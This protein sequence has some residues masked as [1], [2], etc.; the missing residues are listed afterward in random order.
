[1]VENKNIYKGLECSCNH[2]EKIPINRRDLGLYGDVATYGIAITEAYTAYS[3]DK[4]LKKKANKIQKL[5]GGL[6]DNGAKKI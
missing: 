2:F 1:M 5:K 4:Y 3:L 6:M